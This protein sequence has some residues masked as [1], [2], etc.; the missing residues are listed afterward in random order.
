MVR[1]MQEGEH[2]GKFPRDWLETLSVAELESLHSDH[3]EGRTK[4]QYVG[5]SA[6]PKQSPVREVILAPARVVQWASGC[7][8][9]NCPVR[10]RKR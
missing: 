9:G 7:P 2:A 1:H 3:H 4:W 6:R 8:D 10:R 5:G